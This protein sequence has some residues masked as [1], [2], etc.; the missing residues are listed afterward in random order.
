MIAEIP[1][2]RIPRYTASFPGPH[3]DL[4]LASV[5]AGST[6]AQLWEVSNPGEAS[7]RLLWDKGNNVFYFSGDQLGAATQRELAE[8]IAAELPARSL[9]DRSPYFKTR[10]LSPVLDAMLH[11]LFGGVALH[12]LPSLLYRFEQA[13]P[14]GVA[15]PAVPGLR[16][17][18][19]DRTLLDDQ[20]LE[21]IAQVRGEIQWMW[22]SV[23]H[24]CEHGLGCAAIAGH[25]VMCWCTAEYLSADRCGVGIET[26]EA[27]QGRGV[28]TATA[29]EFV[30]QAL[31][32]GITPYWECR[33]D[34]IGS[35]RVA[36]KVGFTRLEQER[37]WVGAFSL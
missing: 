25:R 21:N 5:V 33:A 17:E 11:A 28:A 10:A 9:K 19:I 34:N 16:L 4:V 35:V 2:D 14:A 31:S 37:Y 13:T 20:E 22:P 8:F 36:E 15:A 30:R 3:L 1:P 32:R 12:Q 7:V 24:F 26:A 6:R 29:A 23:E 27:Y 18:T